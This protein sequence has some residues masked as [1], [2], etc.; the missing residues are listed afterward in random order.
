MFDIIDW[1]EYSASVVN[2]SHAE[3][4]P[5]RHQRQPSRIV[6]LLSSS[7]SKQN[8]DRLASQSGSADDAT[9][10]YIK[11]TLCHNSANKDMLGGDDQS[12][13]PLEELL[14]PL[15]SSNDVDVQLYAI[16]A[17]IL[18]QVVQ[19]W[20]NR[21]TPD[22]DF[23]DEIVKIIA[24]CSRGIEERLRHMDLETFVLHE[25]PGLVDSHLYGMSTK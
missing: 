8:H 23:V 15:T 2:M 16:I 19:S 11:R 22:G 18:N 25:L 24:H 1:H 5:S 3:Q 4:R 17:I 9:I 12:Q 14:P 20:Y 7:S 13:R 6:T 10:A 21:I